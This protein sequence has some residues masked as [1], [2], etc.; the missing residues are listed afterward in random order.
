MSALENIAITWP[1]ER[2]LPTPK[3]VSNRKDMVMVETNPTLTNWQSAP[4]LDL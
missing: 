3:Y 2:F 1:M 4:Q